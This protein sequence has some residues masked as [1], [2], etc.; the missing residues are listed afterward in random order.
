MKIQNIIQLVMFTP[1]LLFSDLIGQNRMGNNRLLM[2][3]NQ[4]LQQTPDTFVFSLLAELAKKE[5]GRKRLRDFM[6]SMKPRKIKK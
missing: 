2:K 3:Y 6:K 1:Q 5:S 4:A